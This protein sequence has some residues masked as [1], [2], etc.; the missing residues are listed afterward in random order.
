MG[1]HFVRKITK[2][3][4][5]PRISCLSAQKNL[6]PLP[7]STTTCLLLLDAFSPLPLTVYPWSQAQ[8]ISCVG[9]WETLGLDGGD[10]S[11]PPSPHK[12]VLSDLPLCLS[13]PVFTGRQLAA[14]G[15]IP[16]LSSSSTVFFAPPCCLALLGSLCWPLP[17][18]SS[19]VFSC[20]QQHPAVLDL[21]LLVL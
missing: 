11:L 1:G 18:S 16:A 3:E 6:G 5:S 2:G 10:L 4:T 20:R 14:H 9:I 21:L 19:S 15:L 13:L 7:I 8:L 17:L 12:M